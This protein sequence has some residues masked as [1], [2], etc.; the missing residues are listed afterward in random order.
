MFPVEEVDVDLF[1]LLQVQQLLHQRV[2]VDQEVI[3]VAKLLIT[4]TL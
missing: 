1:Q 4:Q 2:E 3:V